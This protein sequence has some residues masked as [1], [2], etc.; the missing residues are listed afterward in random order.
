MDRH[1]ADLANSGVITQKAAMEKAQDLDGLKQMIH[2][3]ESQNDAMSKS[4]IDF[5]DVYSGANN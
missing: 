1:L 2:R 5:D 3:V 4:V